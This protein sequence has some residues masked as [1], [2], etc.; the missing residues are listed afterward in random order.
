M[1]A[2]G[3]GSSGRK[4]RWVLPAFVVVTALIS[5]VKGVPFTPERIIEMYSGEPYL[6]AYGEVV[7]VGACRSSRRSCAATGWR[8]TGS[9]KRT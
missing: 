2:G 6:A 4:G 8:C 5:S 7:G 9:R 1:E 3:V